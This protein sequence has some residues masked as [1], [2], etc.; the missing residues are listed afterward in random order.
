MGDV[1]ASILQGPRIDPKLGLLSVWNFAC[2]TQKH[3]GRQM[4]TRC[5]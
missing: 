3:A 2:S 5:E 4:P 1:A